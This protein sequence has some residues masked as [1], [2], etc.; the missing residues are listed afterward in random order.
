M[1]G[2]VQSVL[3]IFWRQARRP[4]NSARERSVRGREW[5]LPHLGEFI[6]QPWRLGLV[7]L[8]VQKGDDPLAG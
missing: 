2:H 3:R 4:L 8:V 6:H 1:V 7:G 5:G